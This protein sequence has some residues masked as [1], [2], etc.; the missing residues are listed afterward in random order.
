[1]GAGL[2]EDER[3]LVASEVVLVVAGE[4]GAEHVVI[5]SCSVERLQRGAPR[6]G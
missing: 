1:M 2:I 6:H 5:V 4:D 3:K